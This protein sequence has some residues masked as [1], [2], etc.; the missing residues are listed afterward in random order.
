[1]RFGKNRSN[2]DR[3]VYFLLQIVA[4]VFVVMA[5][6][7]LMRKIGILSGE[8]DRSLTRLVVT[9]LAPS[10][11]FDTI[12][13]N[14]AL[15]KPANWILP[16]V[17]GFGSIV[18]GIAVSRWGAKLFRVP[19]SGARRTFVF[20]TSLHN[21]GYIPL[22]LC[23]ALFDRDT[24]GVLFAYYLGVELAFWSIAVAQLRGHAERGSW[25][26]ALNPPI[27]AI[28]T[29]ILLNAIGAKAWIPSSIATTFHLLAVCAIPMALLLS[30]ALIADYIN[31]D[32]LRHGS[33]TIFASTAVRIGLLPRAHSAL[34]ETCAAGHHPKV[35][36]DCSGRHACGDLPN[37]C[38]QSISW[39]HADGPSG[40]AGHFTHRP[41]HDS[42]LDRIRSA[43]D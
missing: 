36:S 4:P 3:A 26:R 35:G 32:S 9:L 33:R 12:I 16:P 22:P 5:L 42:P 30:G 23:N 2:R 41:H 21:Y 15:A 27:I 6:G 1:M 13:G 11:A 25:R 28:P 20:T 8:A 7:Y 17:M 39:R 31:T 40:R 24:M 19:E 29:A 34:H 37:R 38:H 18:V 14:D 10:L 43:V